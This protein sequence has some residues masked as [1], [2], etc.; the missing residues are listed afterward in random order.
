MKPIKQSTAVDVPATA[1]YPRAVKK[2]DAITRAGGVGKL[3][4]LL[5]ISKQAVSKWADI[6]P[7]QVYR[8]RE[9][10]PRWFARKAA[11]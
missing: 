2:S 6:P 9:M 10:K 8:L 4:E 7:L 3:A 1:R 11:K 5:G